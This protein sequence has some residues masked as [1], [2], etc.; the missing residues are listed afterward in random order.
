MMKA[1]TIPRYRYC[2][3]SAW[4]DRIN[5]RLFPRM[6]ISRI[7]QRRWPAGGTAVSAL[8]FARSLETIRFS[9]R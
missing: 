2:Q 7:H 8:T 1:V 9:G 4:G 3:M 5:Q 6:K